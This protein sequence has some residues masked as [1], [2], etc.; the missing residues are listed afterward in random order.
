MPDKWEYPWYA[1]WDLA[2]HCIPLALIDADFAKHQ[3]VLL[4]REWY[5][6]PN[7]QMPAYEW[8][9]G[10]VN[11]PVHAWAAWRVFQ[12]D[13][14][15]HGGHGR[16]RVPRARISQADAEFHLVGEPQG[17]L[18]AA[19]SSRAAFSGSTTSG[20]ST[21]AR[22]C[23]TGGHINQSD[24]TSWMAMY[25]LNLMRIALELA[26]HNHVYEDIASKFFE[27]FLHIAEAMSTMSSEG[28]GLWDDE[29]KFFYDVLNLPDDGRVRLRIR[30]MVGLI[31]L[32]AV[33]T[34]EPEMLVRLPGFHKRLEWL[35][36]HRPDLAALV[37][38][39][40]SPGRGER[41]LLSLLRGHRMKRLLKRMLDES[42]F[43]SEYGVRALSR[44]HLERP[45]VFRLD[46]VDLSVRLQPG[47]VRLAPIRRQLELARPDLVPA[48]FP[49]HRIAAE[50]SSLLRQRFQSRVPER[51]G[52][53][54]DPRGDRER[55]G[56]SPARASS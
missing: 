4:T 20:S 53:F 8:A 46:G 16:S 36:K 48:Q 30:S 17:H 1:S 35:L 14:K 41:R 56:S 7:G 23:P 40:Q 26:Q 25:A 29:D 52:P 54:P 21:A 19:T 5:M 28:G 38:H 12:I 39:W 27:H 2:F 24:G 32:F 37:S 11:P 55:A 6:H 43:L 33:E 10:D 34:L 31:P 44:A 22:R 3:L 13:R 9:F 47:G 51:F 49:H 18:R 15:Q 50:I 45:Y 42:E